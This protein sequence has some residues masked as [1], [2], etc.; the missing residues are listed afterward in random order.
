MAV[1]VPV[2]VVFALEELLALADFVE[3]DVLV[4]LLLDIELL[5]FDVAVSAMATIRVV[6]VSEET[7]ELV[8]PLV[9]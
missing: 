5:V 9:C 7:L 3:L 2:S 4:L 1:I 6:F 8:D